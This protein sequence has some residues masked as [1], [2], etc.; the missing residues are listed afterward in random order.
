VPS[1]F[2]ELLGTHVYIVHTSCDRGPRSGRRSAARYRGVNV[3]VE[4]VI[5]HF[6][7]DETY[8]ERPKFEGAKYVMSPPLRNAAN[9]AVLWNGVKSPRDQ[10]E[11]R[12]ITRRSG[13]AT[14]KRWERMRSPRFPTASPR[15]RSAWTWCIRTA[16][17][18][19]RFG[20]QT[21]VD[22]CLDAGRASLRPL[23]QE[24]HE[25]KSAAMPISWY[26]TPPFAATFTQKDSHSKVDYNAY[27]GWE[28]KG[29]ASVGDGCEVRSRRGTGSSWGRSD[30][31]NS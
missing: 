19:G 21:M 28:R 11:S 14:R 7:L 12:P 15:C 6:V 18:A 20:L 27:E 26:T 17:S 31:G 30:E 29:R 9:Q 16:S 1:S 23:P 8:A 25:F 24:G 22:A 2:A 5:P 10:H 3:W 13:S 4:S